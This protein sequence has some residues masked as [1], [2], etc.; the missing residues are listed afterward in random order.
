MILFDHEADDSLIAGASEAPVEQPIS[1][2]AHTENRSSHEVHHSE[3]YS[4]YDSLRKQKETLSG[5]VLAWAHNG[6]DVQL[7]D[8]TVTSMP[9]NHIDLDHDRNIAHYFGKT[10]PVRV[11]DVRHEKGVDYIRVSHRMVI[12]DE[13]RKNAKDKLDTIQVGDVI[14]AKI[15]SFNIKD[16]I[17]DL[18]PGIDAEIFGK[19]LSWQRFDH[20]YEICK[21][22]ETMQAKVLEVD[23][24][25][26]YIRLG[27][28]QLTTD[29]LI[30]KYNSTQEESTVKAKVTAI[31]DQGA[32]VELES[33]LTA[34]LPI[35]EISWDRIPTVADGV[36]IG[37]EFDVKILTV[38][39]KRHRIT[40]SKKRLIE[41]PARQREERYRLGSDHDAKIKEVTRGGLVV[42]FDDG[43]E[44][45][46]PRR[47]LSHDRIDKIEDMFR[48][49]KPIEGIRVTEYDRRTGK[50][51]LSL[52]AAEREAQRT[53]LRKYRA[54]SSGS[55]FSIGELASLK[56][57]LEQAEQAG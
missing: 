12:E 27:V 48:K 52:I 57:K 34:F 51:T 29:P 21:R 44:G 53:T 4:K 9:N 33:G 38:D 24:R 36:Q 56:E 14:D 18:G 39:P 19:D 28:K 54:T 49:D 40:C 20:P 23:K 22:G 10:I 32:E 2:P 37:E 50:I 17:V 30:E 31:V 5:K 35:S 1:A 47:E 42:V 26:R 8:G 41:N 43:N 6:L 45:F 16:V 15:K 13:L 55:S 7:D 25:K 3:L 11:L 46:V